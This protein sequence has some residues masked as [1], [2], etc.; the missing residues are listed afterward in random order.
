MFEVAGLGSIEIQTR[1][2]AE[3]F[4]YPGELARF[5]RDSVA[6]P[7][8]IRTRGVRE[9]LFGVEEAAPAEGALVAVD[10]QGSRYAVPAGRRAGP[11][12]PGSRYAAQSAGSTA[13][14]P[15]AG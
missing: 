3:I 9:K 1:S 15:S 8:R 6:G 7:L 14:V 11:P 10:Y 4:D 12:S 5:H 2:L 13:Y